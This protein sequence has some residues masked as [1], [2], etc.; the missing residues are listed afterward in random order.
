MKPISRTRLR[1]VMN[2]HRTT[3]QVERI[4]VGAV[5]YDMYLEHIGRYLFAGPYAAGQM[6]LDAACGTGYGA[7]YLA[8]QSAIRVTGVDLSRRAAAYAGLTYRMRSLHY[9]AGDVTRM[10]FGPRQFTLITSFETVEHLRNPEAF[11]DECR[12]LLKPGATLIISTPN[13]VVHSSQDFTVPYHE[14]EFLLEEF[15]QMVERHFDIRGIYG[16]MPLRPERLAS[17][18]RASASLVHAAS[19]VP[20]RIRRM[21]LPFYEAHVTRNRLLSTI[22]YYLNGPRTVTILRQKE[23]PGPYRILPLD[24]L[25]AGEEFKTYVLVAAAR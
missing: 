1:Q 25:A 20:R 24:R 22:R 2:P 9:C 17:G 12:R 21:L 13:R 4:L 14:K 11:V 19:H 5:S 8:S 6:V 7:Y 16:Q 18:K 15:K 23:V 10:P 3:Q